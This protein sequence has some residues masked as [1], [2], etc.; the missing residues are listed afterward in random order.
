MDVD[1]RVVGS[2]QNEL[3][4]VAE[5]GILGE[6]HLHHVVHVLLELGRTAVAQF[7]VRNFV[8]HPA[9]LRLALIAFLSR[10]ELPR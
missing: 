3:L 8:F 7:R 10:H 2:L 5:V 6:R 1:F 4:E 9:D